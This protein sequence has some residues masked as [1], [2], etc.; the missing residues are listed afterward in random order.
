MSLKIWD[1]T[2]NAAEHKYYNKDGKELQGVT[3]ILKRRI[4]QDEYNGVSQA[5]LQ[6]AADRGHL[7]HSRIELYDS[8]GVGDDMAEVQSYISLI[9]ENNLECLASEYLVSDNEHYASAIDKVYHIKGTPENEVVLSDIKTTYRFNRE[10]VSWQ[11]SVYAHFFERMNP[12]YKVV[13][14]SGIWVREDERRGSI[15]KYI[16]ID[17]KAPIKV[18][19]LLDC[20]IND[21]PFNTSVLPNYINENV[22]RLLFLNE[23]IKAL[24]E[25][26]EAIQREIQESMKK[27][28]VDSVDS[29]LILFTRVASSTRNT[30]DSSRFKQEHAD[31]YEQY[32]KPSVTKESIKLT[33]RS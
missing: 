3:G 2:F 7:I 30:F 23:R 8:M 22:D 31:M 26:K 15:K 33:Y 16:P 28:G 11:L 12:K 5:V 10:Y 27:D 1:G 29:G 19:E 32:L 4:F 13:G 24:T 14:L 9:E 21:T 18:I 6:N 17:R 25:E 20:D